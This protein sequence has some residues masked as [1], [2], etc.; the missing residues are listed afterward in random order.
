MLVP[1]AST[2]RLEGVLRW[3]H[4]VRVPMLFCG[5]SG[6]GKT[7]ILT[8]C[9]AALEPATHVWVRLLMTPHTTRPLYD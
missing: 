2:A 9:L 6:T 7:A 4:A 5:P 8:R 1:T 3:L